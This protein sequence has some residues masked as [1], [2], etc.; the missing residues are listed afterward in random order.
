MPATHFR[1]PLV[2]G[3]QA[4]ASLR[5]VQ[6]YAYRNGMG[7]VPSAEWV[8]YHEDFNVGIASNAPTGATAII[9]TGATLLAADVDAGDIGAGGAGVITSDGTTEGVG[10]YYPKNVALGDGKK[11][12]MEVRVYTDDADDTDV[13]F[14][15]SEV[16]AT[17][18]PE[19]LWTTTATD[20]ISFGVL[21]GDAT[22][23]MLADKN[24][25]GTSVKLG[26]HDLSDATWHV[27]AIEVVGTAGGSTMEV[28][29]YVDGALSVTWGTETSVPDDLN[30]A[31]FFGART[32][33]DAAHN[34]YFD[35]VRWV[36]ER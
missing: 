9:D 4:G 17:T 10:C 27:L 31:P 11:F 28:Y 5:G 26:V 24:N 25:A 12:F 29:G 18:N 35:Y 23:G 1:G 8:V 7:M 20:L 14:G 32:G 33:G 2:H 36:Y 16:N 19:D 30:L 22:V 6:P 21:D 15:L 13:Q 3:P 34:V